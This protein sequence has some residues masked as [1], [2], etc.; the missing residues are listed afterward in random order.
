MDMQFGTVLKQIRET[1]G[2]TQAEVARHFGH[3]ANWLCRIERGERKLKV[4]TLVKLCK[5]YGVSPE[6]IFKLVE[7][8]GDNNS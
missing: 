8:A 3:G 7:G 6:E 2:L 5:I 4:Q 1:K